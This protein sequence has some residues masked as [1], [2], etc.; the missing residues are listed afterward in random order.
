MMTLLRLAVEFFIIGLF[1]VGGGM[2]TV[3]FLM[4]LSERS[5]WFSLQ[6]LTSMIAISE[7]TP[8][9]IGINMATYVGYHVYGLLGAVI[10]PVALTIPAFLIILLLAKIIARLRGNARFE[11]IFAAVRPASIGLISAVLLQ[12]SITTFFPQASGSVQWKSMLLFLVIAAGLFTPKVKRLPIPVF[13]L[14]S[15]LC[16]ILFQLAP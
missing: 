1:S 2:A 3:P 10:A 4:S 5:G 7:A 12:L 11:A 14:F 8:G 6:N 15:A 16:G 13:L 9:P